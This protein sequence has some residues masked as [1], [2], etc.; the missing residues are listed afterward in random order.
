M[1]EDRI[2]AK[3]PK[4]EKDR[5]Q[6][7]EIVDSFLENGRRKILVEARSDEYKLDISNA[8]YDLFTGRLDISDDET[9][10]GETVYFIDKNE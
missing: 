4:R 9:P 5:W 7:G 3:E 8:I 10:V 2:R 6:K 1:S